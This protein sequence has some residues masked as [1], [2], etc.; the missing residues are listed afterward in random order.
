MSGPGGHATYVLQSVPGGW[1]G[2]VL[3]SQ[4][5]EH[6]FAGGM[7]AF[8]AQPMQPMQPMQLSGGALPARLPTPG[9]NLVH[10]LSQLSWGAGT[11]DSSMVFLQDP[12]DLSLSNWQGLQPMQ[13]MQATQGMQGM[14]GPIQLTAVQ[15]PMGATTQWLQCPAELLPMLAVPVGG[16]NWVQGGPKGLGGA[17]QASPQT[18]QP[19]Q[20]V[21]PMQPVI[22]HT[23]STALRE[24]GTPS[25]VTWPGIFASLSPGLAD[26]GRNLPLFHP[27][28]SPGQQGVELH[29]GSPPAP[30]HH[31]SIFHPAPSQIP[32]GF[33]PPGMQGLQPRGPSSPLPPPLVRA[34]ATQTPPGY[35]PP[36][37][38]LHPSFGPASTQPRSGATPALLPVPPPSANDPPFELPIDEQDLPVVALEGRVQPSHAVRQV[39]GRWVLGAVKCQE[40]VLQGEAGHALIS[41]SQVSI[42]GGDER[43]WEQCVRPT[44]HNRCNRFVHP[45]SWR[46]LPV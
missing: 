39:S 30:S 3:P 41:V 13:P 9:S 8:P 5:T 6:V 11:K 18:M 46:F 19:M 26:L 16:G 10:P 20:F 2:A 28:N 17:L 29:L 22:Q 31:P 23:S 32:A 43:M 40:G 15:V 12:Q 7:A 44:V 21:Q 38:Q 24:E 34:P 36:A 27:A 42:W 37:V 25:G 45:A 1:G 35:H 33:Q 14:Q 4:T